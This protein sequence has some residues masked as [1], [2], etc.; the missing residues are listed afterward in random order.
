MS[1]SISPRTNRI[2][3]V[4]I[5]LG[6]AVV[7]VGALAK[8]IHLSWADY[9]LIVGLLTEAL[10]FVIYAFLPPPE[11][12]GVSSDSA[13]GTTDV[14]LAKLESAKIDQAAFDKLSTSFERLNDTAM[15]LGDIA[16]MAKSSKEFAQNTSTAATSMG[17]INEA[18]LG[19]SNNLAGF[20][21]ATS[22][23]KDLTAQFEMMEKSMEAMNQY[24]GKLTEASLAMSSSAQDAIRAKEQIGILADNLTKLNQIYGNIIVAMQGR[25]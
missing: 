24:Y 7:L 12:G 17:G 23:A 8:I 18:I 19:V 16:D 10:I 20:S 15:Y 4:V 3:N 21:T 14:V 13:S 22:G 25:A 5:S 1:N 11:I 6:A 2:V 9:A